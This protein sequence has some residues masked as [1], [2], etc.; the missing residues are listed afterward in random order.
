MTTKVKM[1]LSAKAIKLNYEGVDLD[2]ELKSFARN[3]HYGFDLKLDGTR[4]IAKK[5]KDG[6]VILYGRGTRQAENGR[7]QTTYNTHFPEIVKVLESLT[8]E[9][10]EFDGELVVY[11]KDGEE[12]FSLL[13]KR[14]TRKHN[15]EDVMDKF[16]ATYMIFD[17][18]E[19]AGINIEDQSF[20]VRRKYLANAFKKK[21]MSSDSPPK[22]INILPIYISENDKFNLAKSVIRR[23]KEGIMIKD[24]TS[25]YYR[26]RT[27][28]ILKAKRTFTEDFFVMGRSEG[29]G[30][31]KEYFGA[32]HCYKWDN[33]PVWVTDVGGGYT[34]SF[35]R[36]FTRATES[37]EVLSD[38]AAVN[39]FHQLRDEDT[40]I[41][42]EIEHYGSL[43]DG[44]RHPNF[45][46][47][48]TD[49]DP[50]DCDGIPR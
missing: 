26:G 22:H 42:V 30:K 45:K 37:M 8:L 36:Y 33:G 29:T 39:M 7:V 25:P 28:V 12:D 31:R 40:L 20:Q 21:F 6:P 5:E 19:I 11:N 38:L 3:P 27:D 13:Q 18:M 17:I 34:D 2:L 1:M 48:R 43:K 23:N 10:F 44:R 47:I 49:K 32:L 4:M 46:R 35:L 41:I 50:S 9:S 16:P 14:T 24:L 15:I